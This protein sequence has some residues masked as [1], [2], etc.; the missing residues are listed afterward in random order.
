[1]SIK[2]LPPPDFSDDD[3]AQI[4]TDL[5]ALKKALIGEF[6]KRCKLPKSGTK[7]QIRERIE[8]ALEDGTVSLSQIV[9][10]L[11][12]VIPW[13]KQH[14]Y[15]YKGPQRSIANWKKTDWLAKLLKKHRLGKY[16]NA[17]L[18]L[19]LP[20]KMKV[21]SILHDVQRLA[22]AAL[23]ALV[24]S[25]RGRW[26]NRPGG[27]DGGRPTRQFHLFTGSGGDETPLNL[28]NQEVLSPSPPMRSRDDG[29][30][31][32]EQGDADGD[33]WEGWVTV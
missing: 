14:V 24:S 11:D 30:D 27:T 2:S 6:L 25:G 18:P 8:G 20:D 9:H 13:G 33:V 5:L 10:F 29:P 7:E 12:E 28:G 1:M 4:V 32:D 21:S 16:L 31:G 26:A 15:L 19:V 23:A 17:S 3:Q 22:E